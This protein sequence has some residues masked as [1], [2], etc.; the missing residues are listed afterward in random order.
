MLRQSL[1]Q[2]ERL[3]HCIGRLHDAESR[4]WGQAC[5]YNGLRPPGWSLRQSAWEMQREAATGPSQSR[6]RSYSIE[7]YVKKSRALLEVI[8]KEAEW[9]THKRLLSRVGPRPFPPPSDPNFSLF[10]LFSPSLHNPPTGSS[11][12]NSIHDCGPEPSFL[13]LAFNF[14]YLNLYSAVCQEVR[15]FGVLRGPETT[16][17]LSLRHAPSAE[18]TRL[19]SSTPVSFG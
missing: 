7:A 14:I 1:K 16:H 18:P 19:L 8:K 12:T 17:Q 2:F 5:R 9:W 3:A 11:N 13:T 15:P 4:D 6:E 10:S